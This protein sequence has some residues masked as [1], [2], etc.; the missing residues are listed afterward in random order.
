MKGDLIDLDDVARFAREFMWVAV[1]F[2]FLLE[3]FLSSLCLHGFEYCCGRGVFY[4]VCVRAC[5]VQCIGIVLTHS[6]PSDMHLI[7]G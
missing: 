6:P 1:L 7:D 4:G 5:D 2:T 3:L